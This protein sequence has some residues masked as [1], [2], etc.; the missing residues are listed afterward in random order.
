MA[1]KVI[2]APINL[3]FDTTP[4][5]WILNRFSKD[6]EKL[7]GDMFEMVFECI[8]C[9]TSFTIVIYVCAL[10]SIWTLLCLPIIGLLMFLLI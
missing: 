9:F 1:F 6:I 8:D 2:H 10:V 7:D 5:G 3:F 4:S